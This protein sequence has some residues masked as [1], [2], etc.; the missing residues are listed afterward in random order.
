MKKNFLSKAISSILALTMISAAMP[1]VNAGAASSV[2][3]YVPNAEP[4]GV[5]SSWA[6][7]QELASK[8]TAPTEYQQRCIYFE[9]GSWW[10]EQL[11]KEGDKDVTWWAAPVSL[12]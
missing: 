8:T 5:E 11:K 2:S 6:G 10:G 9:D 12:S 7:T 3:M 1:I 4:S